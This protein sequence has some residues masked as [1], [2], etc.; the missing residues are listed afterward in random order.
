MAT[1]L[2]LAAL[3]VAPALHGV[4]A[5][6]AQTAAQDSPGQK[7]VEPGGDRAK[8]LSNQLSSPFCPGKTL[9]GCTS[10]A[11]AEWRKDIRDWVDD[12]V[13][14]QEIKRRL[15]ER[16]G[17][18]DLIAA[19]SS[20]FSNGWL[21]FSIAASLLILGLASRRIFTR[22]G[23]DTGKGAADDEKFDGSD[24]NIDEK[25]DQKLDDELALLD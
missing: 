12:G 2:T 8:T 13:S 20:G 18:Q 14:S 11:A 24:E 7:D 4:S 19:P 23:G 9:D 16:A 1:W 17:G 22:R 21:I 5:A 10:P 15:S 25:Y 6:V 3:L